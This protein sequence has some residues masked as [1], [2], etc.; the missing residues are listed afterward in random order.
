VSGVGVC[1]LQLA[2]NRRRR[3]DVATQYVVALRYGEGMRTV[4][5]GTRPPEI[6]ALIA[7]R[8]ARGLDL[9]DELW[10]GDYHMNPAPHPRHGIIDHQLASLLYG[11]AR[12]LALVP[13]GVFNLG[14]EAN[15]RV[16]DL[17]YCRTQP[18]TVFVP[19]AAAVVEI[20]SPGDETFEKLPHY[21]AF[22][23]EEVFVIDP[24]ERTVR[25]FRGLEETPDS[26]VFGFSAQWLAAQIDWPG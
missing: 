25:M 7:Q 1:G 2:S 21:A 6:E 17:G 4:V 23:V 10:N 13:L 22:G 15:Y 18:D 20:V 12:E 26:A 24:Q 9:F 16:P 11:R 5:V 8:R 3:T 19:T 14:T